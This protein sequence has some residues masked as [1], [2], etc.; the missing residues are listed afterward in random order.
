MDA[1]LPGTVAEP[2]SRLERF[3]LSTHRALDKRLSP[4]GVWVMRRSNGKV[5]KA[6]NVH[7]LVLTT[8]GRRS[9]RERPVVLQYFPDGEAMV[10]VAANDG[11]AAPP[12]WYFNL[13]ASGEAV[14][15]VDGRRKAIRVSELE[16]DEAALWWQRILAA[17]PA[18]ELYRRATSRPFPILRLVPT[19]PDRGATSVATRE[20]GQAGRPTIVLLHGVG[21][22][23]SM[24]SDLMA[25][26]PGY[27]CLAPD[28]PGHGRS[29][30]IPWRSRAASA[31][32]V[33]ELIERRETGGRAHVVGL[34]LGGSV[35]LELLSM[36]P[37]LLDHVIVDGCAAV[38][39]PFAGPMKVGVSAISPFLRFAPVARLIGRTFGV[40]SDDAL[41]A[42]VRQMQ[43]VE[44]RSFRRAFADANEMR[45][46]AALLRAPCP[47]LL[48]AG[49]REMRHVR[50]SN[51][52]LARRMT[53]AD[54]RFMP[55]A[56]HGWG[57]AQFPD[58]HRRMVLAW[59]EDRPL[60]EELSV[61]AVRSADR[62][63][64]GQTSIRPL[65]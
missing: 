61:E 33:A 23:G 22:D 48:V 45:A 39:N 20:V 31:Q 30:S 64:V 10:V 29:R 28:L 43:A 42:F 51:A 62:E 34:S 32:L 44:P 5:T 54:A 17:A 15:E 36:R 56:N 4:L 1:P 52:L 53:R 2:L 8:R 59:I 13:S 12:G 25:R 3:K 7:A 26:L 9:G 63:P 37:D 6:W 24:W 19:E 47:T 11:G 38:R 46:T 14:V 55:G 41:D 58:I 18:Y 27:H 40:R 57:P 50:A 35:A 60:P 21:N 49:E 65:R 16:G